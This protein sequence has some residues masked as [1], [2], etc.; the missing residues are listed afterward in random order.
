[1]DEKPHI[2][3]T[4]PDSFG[5]HWVYV[6]DLEVRGLS[7][8]RFGGVIFLICVWFVA[9]GALE[10]VLGS[11]SSLPRLIYGVV[12]FVTGCIKNI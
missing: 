9:I 6:S 3:L 1:M 2:V 10:I 4:Q 12:L 8:G 7:K 5:R 11:S